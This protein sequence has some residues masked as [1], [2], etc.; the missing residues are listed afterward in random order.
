MTLAD[1]C[2]AAGDHILDHRRVDPGAG[3][4]TSQH[5]A[6]QLDGMRS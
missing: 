1:L 5:G 6:E 4:Q 2:N 3:L